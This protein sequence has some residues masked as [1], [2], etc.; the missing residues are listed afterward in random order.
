DKIEVPLDSVEEEVKEAALQS[1][2]I[3]K[4]NIDFSKVK[5]I[6]VKNKLLNIVVKK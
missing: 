4:L 1:K 5:F 6:F 3:S 2:K